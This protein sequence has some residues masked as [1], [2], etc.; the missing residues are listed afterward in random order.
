MDNEMP[1]MTG[2]EAMGLI[3][4]MSHQPKC[5]AVSAA[6]LEEDYKRYREAGFDDVIAKPFEFS[7]VFDCLSKQLGVTFEYL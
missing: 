7:T 2:L 3:L 4:K 5:I 6:V 1:I